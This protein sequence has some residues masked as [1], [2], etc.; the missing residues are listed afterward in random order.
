MNDGPSEAS[1]GAT[2]AT[3]AATNAGMNEPPAR[4]RSLHR[5]LTSLA[6]R[7]VAERVAVIGA[8]M[9]GFLGWYTAYLVYA[10]S[11]PDLFPYLNR[12]FLPAITAVIAALLG[13]WCVLTGIAVWLRR[14]APAARTEQWMGDATAHCFLL[15]VGWGSYVTGYHS[16]L[17]LGVA[18]GVPESDLSCSTGRPC[19]GRSPCS[20][21]RCWQPISPISSA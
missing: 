3:G 11:R 17:F 1:S 7:P 4:R 14:R 19:C 2:P 20:C 12:S 16:S 13:V 10:S 18:L 9:L 6:E 8:L 15:T 21:W 5:Q